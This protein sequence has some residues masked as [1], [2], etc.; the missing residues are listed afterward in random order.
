MVD[1]V[2]HK[3]F[4]K[5]DVFFSHMKK[6]NSPEKPHLKRATKTLPTSKRKALLSY[7]VRTESPDVKWFERDGLI[8]VEYPKNFTRFEKWLH[9]KLGGPTTI[10]RPLDKIGSDIWLLCDGK[11]T[12]LEICNIIGEKYKEEI[13]PVF[14]RVP[15][16]I[17]QLMLLGLII[18]KTKEELDREKARIVDEIE[19]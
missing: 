6:E 7:P 4:K 15:A 18:P 8:V 2:S 1:K 11:H 13:E 12:L 17:S 16:F 9:K 3:I 19:L 5:K 14:R 10:K